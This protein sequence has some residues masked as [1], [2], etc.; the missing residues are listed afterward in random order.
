MFQIGISFMTKSDEY[1]GNL[2]KNL[3]KALC[4]VAYSVSKNKRK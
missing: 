3:I 1:E 2:P 4:V